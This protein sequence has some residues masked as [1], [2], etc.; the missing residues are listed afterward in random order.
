MYAPQQQFALPTKEAR[1][2]RSKFERSLSVRE[3]LATGQIQMLPGGHFHDNR[4]VRDDVYYRERVGPNVPDCSG[5]INPARKDP[6]V[7]RQRA[8]QKPLQGD[9]LSCLRPPWTRQSSPD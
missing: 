2:R 1:P 9:V 5:V 7:V 3:G 6:A 4:C 8:I